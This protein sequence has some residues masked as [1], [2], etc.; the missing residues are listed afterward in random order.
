MIADATGNDVQIIVKGQ[1]KR[2]SAYMAMF[3]MRVIIFPL[4]EQGDALIHAISNPDLSVQSYMHSGIAIIASS[5]IGK[6]Q[7]DLHSRIRFECPCLI[8]D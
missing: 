2:T 1:E 3:D 4:R 6:E 8:T 7:S 5:K